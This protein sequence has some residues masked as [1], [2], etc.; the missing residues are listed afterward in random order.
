MTTQRTTSEL[1]R[2]KV[3]SRAI[4]GTVGL[5][6]ATTGAT[7]AAASAAAATDP[8][9]ITYDVACLLNTF[10][11]VLASGATD[12]FS[13]FRG[14]TFF[15]EGELYPAGT[16][17]DGATDYD[18]ASDTAIG[19]W[20]CRGWFINRTGRAGEADRPEPHV[21]THQ[22][23]LIERISPEHLFPADQLSSSG[24]EGTATPQLAVRSVVGGAGRYAGA[25]GQVIQHTIGANT[26]AGP[27]FRFAFQLRRPPA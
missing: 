1:D 23:Y 27:N 19:H 24:L 10:T 25:A 5:T 8:K 13:D 6:A 14:T 26:T 21:L 11:P 4:W 16:I 20:L 3:L 22:E 18:P 17:P 7:W 2:R 12:P 15:V 9:V